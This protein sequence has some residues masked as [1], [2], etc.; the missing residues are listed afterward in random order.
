MAVGPSY[1]RRA[2]PLHLLQRRIG[3]DDVRDVREPVDDLNASEHT[4]GAAW[5]FGRIGDRHS[6]AKRNP[7]ADALIRVF[8]KI[9]CHRRA[10]SQLENG[11]VADR[12]ALAVD[13]A[14]P[15]RARKV[16]IGRWYDALM[17]AVWRPLTMP[18]IGK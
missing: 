16:G 14:Q 8:C 2:L 7:L 1:R 4:G 13:E 17:R 3:Q 12:T 11:K 6:C 9:Q 18:N 15:Q 5:E 10:A